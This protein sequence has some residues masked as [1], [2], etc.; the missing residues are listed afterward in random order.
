MW[1]SILQNIHLIGFLVAE[2]GPHGA[3]TLNAAKG[4]LI[5]GIL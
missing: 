2:K 3:R 5:E 1:Q 4:E